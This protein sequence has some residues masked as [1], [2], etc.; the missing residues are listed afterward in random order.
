MSSHGIF[1]ANPAERF[2]CLIGT[3]LGAAVYEPQA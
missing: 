1:S 2:T 3:D